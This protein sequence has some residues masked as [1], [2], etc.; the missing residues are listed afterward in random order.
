M[1]VLFVGLDHVA[2][3]RQAGGSRD[4]DPVIVA[5]LAELAGAGGLSRTI[6][7]ERNGM[8][9]RDV[10]L[11]RDTVR[12]VLNVCLPPLDEWVKL[13]LAIRPDLVT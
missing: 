1:S 10:R 12:S 13:A 5:G 4:P 2:T 3:L 7:R 6:G 9:E 8:Q 11:L